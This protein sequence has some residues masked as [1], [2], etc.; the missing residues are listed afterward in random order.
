MSSEPVSGLYEQLV[1]VELKRLLGTLEPVHVDIGSPDA[2]DAHVAVADHLRRI[3]ERALRAVP[4]AERPTR[5][6]EL[7]NS[8]L[9]WLREEGESVES[10]PPGQD[11]VVPLK[12]LREVRAVGR[13]A[14]FSQATP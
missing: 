11:L 1:T 13:G 9:V 14:A 8:L 6:A 3:I 2:A 12:V 5:Q 10:A 7:C 4:E